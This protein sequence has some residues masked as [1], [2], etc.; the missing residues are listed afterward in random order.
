[1]SATETG[2]A[3][4]GPNRFAMMGK[5][6]TAKQFAIQSGWRAGWLF[7]QVTGW[8]ATAKPLNQR[9][10]P[11]SRGSNGACEQGSGERT[12]SCKW[13]NVLVE[14]AGGSRDLRKAELGWLVGS[15][16][17]PRGRDYRGE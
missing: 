3:K 11:G 13:I 6:A 14:I 8:A 9:T 17:K 12:S 1:M 10:E 16:S 2:D 15:Q 7:V 5:Q 4:G